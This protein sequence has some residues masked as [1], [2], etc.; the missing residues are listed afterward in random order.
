MLVILNNKIFNLNM[1]ET[2]KPLN[3]GSTYRDRISFFRDCGEC[4]YAA[5]DT[6]EE[7][8]SEWDRIKELVVK[9]CG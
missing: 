8:D 9:N 1:Y 4:E 2:V 5:Y 3:K 6:V 7:R